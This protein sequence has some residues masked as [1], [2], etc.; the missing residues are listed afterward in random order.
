MSEAEFRDELLTAADAF[1]AM[2]EYLKAYH[3]Q[4]PTYDLRDVLSEMNPAYGGKS[5]DPAAWFDWEQAVRR[6]QTRRRVDGGVRLNVTNSSA[7]PNSLV[8]E[9]AGE[10]H[11]IEP[12]QTRVVRYV[13]DPEPALSID[14][15]D[16]ETKIWEEGVGTLEIEPDGR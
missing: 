11:P 13:G 7:E 10:V 9:P 14:V 5:S 3:E 8:L 6:A 4:S 15:G 1:A 12:G 2:F 16:G